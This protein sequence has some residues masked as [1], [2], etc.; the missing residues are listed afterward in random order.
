M[1]LKIRKVGNGYIFTDR[2]GNEHIYSKTEELFAQLLLLLEGRATTFSGDS[3]GEVKI[4]RTPDDKSSDV[5]SYGYDKTLHQTG[6]INVEVYD[7]NV[8]SCW[9]RC[10]A[11]PFTQT[12][13]N[14]SRA[15]DM[16]DMYSTNVDN[17]IVGID[18][19]K[20]K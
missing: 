7:G 19:V 17:N 13:I 2:L 10:M 8:I 12:N 14:R 9:F 6:E 11:L 15:A 1:D 20:K 3:F 4:L 16:L 5:M 18:I